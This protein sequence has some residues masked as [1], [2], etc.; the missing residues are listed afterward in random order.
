MSNSSYTRIFIIILF[1]MSIIENNINAQ[2]LEIG[3]T[4]YDI[5]T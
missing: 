4:K 1:I 3:W 5:C 2:H